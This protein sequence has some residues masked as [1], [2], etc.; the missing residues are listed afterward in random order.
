[1]NQRPTPLTVFGVLNIVFGAFTLLIAPFA[2]YGSLAR[3]GATGNPVLDMMAASPGLRTWQI[4]SAVL[5]IIAAI[6]LIAAGIGLLR[7]LPWGRLLSMGYS[8][9]AI[10]IAVIGV[11]INYFLL[12]RPLLAQVSQSNDPAVTAGAIGGAVGGSFGSCIGLI[13]PVLLLYFMTR[14]DI[15]Q[16]VNQGGSQ[17][18]SS[19]PPP[20]PPGQGF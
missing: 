20:M 17:P 9:Y 12:V 2:L 7:M 6:V 5:G 10:F 1:M 8:I 14:P 16:A 18:P 3:Q 15:I 4:T 13:Y 11:P 19:V